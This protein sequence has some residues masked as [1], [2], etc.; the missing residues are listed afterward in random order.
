MKLNKALLAATA[1]P[2]ALALA[3][4]SKHSNGSNGGGI[5]LTAGLTADSQGDWASKKLNDGATLTANAATSTSIARYGNG[6]AGSASPANFSIKKNA[7]GGVDMTVNGETVSFTADDQFREDGWEKTAGNYKALVNRKPGGASTSNALDG[8]DESYLQVWE[9]DSTTDDGKN[10]LGY[11]V[12]G[13]ETKP[14]TLS[15]HANATYKGTAHADTFLVADAYERTGVKGD[16]TLTANFTEGKVT[17]QIDNIEG[18][19]RGAET[20]YVWSDWVALG[21]DSNV[22]MTKANISSNGF[23]G[24]KLVAHDP[25]G[26]LGSLGG[27][28]YSGRFYGPDADQV[29]GVMTIKGTAGEDKFVGRG[30][31]TG[32]KQ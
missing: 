22:E 18:R 24:G 3:G 27:S 10:L 25:S 8:T 23:A 20:G 30:Y 12:V 26:E 32:N 15:G 7:D 13:A 1:V 14:A 5:D 6:T 17:G 11:A 28:T 29:G 16:L 9:Y 21:P 4:C 19:V 31:F 2:V